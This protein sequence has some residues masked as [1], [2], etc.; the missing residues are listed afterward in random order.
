ML[1]TLSRIDIRKHMRDLNLI[2]GYI[3]YLFIIKTIFSSGCSSKSLTLNLVVVHEKLDSSR[4]S[5]S[6]IETW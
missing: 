5:K 6:L 4:P 1:A 2:I 3:Q